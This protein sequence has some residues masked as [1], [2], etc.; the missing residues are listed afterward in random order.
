[1]KAGTFSSIVIQPRIKANGI[2]GENGDAEIW[3]SDDERRL[4]LRI[5]SRFAKFSLNLSLESYVP[6]YLASR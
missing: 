3:F 1:M 4:P 2:F 6:G 5:K